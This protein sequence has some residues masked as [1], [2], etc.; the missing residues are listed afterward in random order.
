MTMNL[1]RSAPVREVAFFSV[2]QMRN[3]A[4]EVFVQD[5]VSDFKCPNGDPYSLIFH[6]VSYFTMLNKSVLFKCVYI[7]SNVLSIAITL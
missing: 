5:K 2:L 4:T 6:K 3:R 1:S 7:F